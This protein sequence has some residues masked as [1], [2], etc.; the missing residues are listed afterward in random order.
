MLLVFPSRGH[1]RQPAAEIPCRQLLGMQEGNTNAEK[2][3]DCDRYVQ[4]ISLTNQGP[5]A[6]VLLVA[7]TSVV[8][9][10]T[11]FLL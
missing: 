6:S 3:D 7:W 2:M 4:R 8:W 9:Y 1:M 10:T 11:L 5:A